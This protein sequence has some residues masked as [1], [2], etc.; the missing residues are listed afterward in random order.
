MRIAQISSLWFQTPPSR[1]GGAEMSI[2]LLTEGLVRKNHD[3]VLFASGDSVTAGKLISPYSTSFNDSHFDTVSQSGMVY[4][5]IY[6][7]LQENAKK[8][9]D[10]V[11]FHLA[12]WSDFIYFL[13]VEQLHTRCIFTV[14]YSV[15]KKKTL[16]VEYE[17]LSRF[18]NLNYVS[19]SKSQQR[20]KLHLN[21]IA[22]IY[23][24]IDPTIYTYKEKPGNYFLWVG[25][26]HPIKGLHL[27]IKAA[28]AANV[29]LVIA[30]KINTHIPLAYEYWLK[31][32]RPLIDGKQI[33]YKGETTRKQTAH[34][35]QNA[36]G[37][38]NPIQW[39]EPFGLVMIESMSCG[40]PVIVFDRGSARELVVHN[41]TGF[42]VKTVDEMVQKIKKVQTISRFDCYKHVQTHFNQ[43]LMVGSYET[44]YRTVK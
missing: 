11:H 34:L 1:Y 40:T 32:I 31:Q 18:K 28:K 19:I 25:S 5:N 42:I 20:E 15:P 21:W 37:F 8:K 24:T 41:K 4:T 2:S 13:F 16:P 7:L 39:E 3:V 38:L 33:I 26:I 44:I 27:A 43:D 17:F 35:M 10:I 14:R 30:G 36:R 12:V 6:N 22:N 29:Q 23:N 9:F